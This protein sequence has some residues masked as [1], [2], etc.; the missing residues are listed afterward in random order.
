MNKRAAFGIRWQ[1]TS[2]D[3]LEALDNCLAEMRLYK[4]TTV[5]PAPLWPTMTVSGVS[6][7]IRA[8]SWGE[9][10]RIPKIRSLSIELMRIMRWSRGVYLQMLLLKNLLCLWEIEERV[11]L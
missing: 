11:V 4:G 6:N 1:V 3:K 9:K 10:E 2:G 5:L 8:I 7:S